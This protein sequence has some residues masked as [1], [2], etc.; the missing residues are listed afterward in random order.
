VAETPFPEFLHALLRGD[1]QAAAEWKRHYAPHLRRLA[2]RRLMAS[3]PRSASDSV[4]LPQ[5]VWIKVITALRA[6]RYLDVQS[7]EAFRQLLTRIANNALTDLMR[8]EGRARPQRP[9]ADAKPPDQAVRDT[10]DPGSSPSQ[11]VAREEAVSRFRDRL[12]AELR[13]VYHWRQQGWTWDRIGKAVGEAAN[14]LRIRYRREH[15][16][17][18][19]ALGLAESKED[20]GPTP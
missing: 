14:T 18:T 19:R 3:G 9:A 8:K 10:P 4:D 17:I 6:S 7:P 2:R 1:A 5:L 15:R 13:Q 20:G 11:H 16:R 12:P